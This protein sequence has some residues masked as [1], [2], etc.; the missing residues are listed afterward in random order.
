MEAKVADILTGA[1]DEYVHSADLNVLMKQ[2]VQA[3][4]EERSVWSDLTRSVHR[5]LGGRSQAIDPVSA[6]VEMIFLASDIMDDLQDQDHMEKPWMQCPREY[7]M[8]AMTSFIM[9]AYGELGRLRQHGPEGG[10]LIE[11]VSRLLAMSVNGQQKDLNRYVQTEAEYF[12]MVQ[13]KSGSLLRF[14]FYMG[15]A[16]VETRREQAAVQLND[17]ADCLAVMAQL[18]ND[19]GDLLR[20][21]VKNDLLHKKKTLPTLFLLEHSESDFPVLKQFYEGRLS[22]DEFLKH[23]QACLQYV[24]DSGCVEYVKV[25]RALYLQRAVKLLDSIEA[26][27]EWKKRFK[28]LAFG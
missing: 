13:E 21:D 23:K 10:P 5:M 24:T 1:V 22:R 12:H 19:L 26:V 20:Y 11:E 16:L 25:I 28:Q 2:F 15:Y 14:A 4:V 7:A 17:L 6:A 27:P 9:C 18:D 8:N 3:K